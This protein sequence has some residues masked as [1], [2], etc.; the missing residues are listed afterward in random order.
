MTVEMLLAALLIVTNILWAI[1]THRLINKLMSRSFF[2]YREAHLQEEKL[3]AKMGTK[4][5]ND[6]EDFGQ[7]DEIMS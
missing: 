7:L 3:G 2:E 6:F 4:P 5:P 1:N